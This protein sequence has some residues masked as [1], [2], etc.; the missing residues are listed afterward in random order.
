VL[1]LSIDRDPV[2]YDATRSASTADLRAIRR[3][4][5]CPGGCYRTGCLASSTDRVGCSEHQSRGAGVGGGFTELSGIVFVP[6]SAAI[7]SPMNA[8]VPVAIAATP[9]MT[10]VAAAITCLRIFPTPDVSMNMDSLSTTSLLWL[11]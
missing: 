3:A 6:V 10:A 4:N 8:L 7:A 1:G 9:R 11:L 2:P 5:W